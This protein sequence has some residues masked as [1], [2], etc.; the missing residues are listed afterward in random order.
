MSNQLR[1]EGV[2][3]GPVFWLF[4]K[5][6]ISPTIPQALSFSLLPNTR[7]FPRRGKNLPSF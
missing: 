3:K 5:V 4:L 7:E 2:K 6:Q 1:K